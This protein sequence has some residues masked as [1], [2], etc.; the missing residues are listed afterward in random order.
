MGSEVV[1]Y[2]GEEREGFYVEPMMKRAWYAQLE[3]VKEIDRICKRHDIKYFA[4]WGT[5]LGQVRH[6]GFIPWDDDVDLAMQREDYERFRY[7]AEKE[8]PEGWK[9]LSVHDEG[10]EE[11][12]LR[13]VNSEQI[14]LDKA[15]LNRFHGC[16]YAV[17]A[18][19]FV[20]DHIPRKKE[21]EEFQLHLLNTVSTVAKYWDKLDDIQETL[22][23]IEEIIGCKLDRTGSI[24]KQMLCLADKVCAMYYDDE[25]DEVTMICYLTK[26][27]NFR[28][29]VSCFDEIIEAPFENIMIPI[30]AN[31]DRILKISYGDD[32][33][34]PKQYCGHDY[35]FYKKQ[36]AKLREYVEIGD[37][38]LAEYF[39]V[40]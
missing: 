22:E 5:L 24:K 20:I 31:Y 17:G 21:E 28:F 13:V 12:V 10:W 27:P 2:E 26:S 16:P 23:N 8:L 37:E 19:I 15:F 4:F 6:H 11:M 40:M 38:V 25:A 1:N 35:P 9:V 14:R 18:D 36:L 39:G 3:V 7:F 32:Y 30:P 34:V 29:P 33:M